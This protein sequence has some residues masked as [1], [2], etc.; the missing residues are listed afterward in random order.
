MWAC[1]R[2]TLNTLLIDR[3]IIRPAVGVNLL[4]ISLKLGTVK[5]WVSL[6]K[7]DGVLLRGSL[8]VPLVINVTEN[9]GNEGEV[10]AGEV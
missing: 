2:F 4:H 9:L 10:F 3:A 6:L 1:V 7:K 5:P 8:P